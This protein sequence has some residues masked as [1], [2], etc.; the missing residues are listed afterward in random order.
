MDLKAYRADESWAT[1]RMIVI[2]LTYD[3]ALRQ[4]LHEYGDDDNDVPLPPI[5]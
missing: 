1:T 4:V 3:S 5:R 2:G